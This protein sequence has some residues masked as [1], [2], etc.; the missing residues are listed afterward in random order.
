[1]QTL[2]LISYCGYLFTGLSLS[3]CGTVYPAH[4]MLYAPMGINNFF[5]AQKNETHV[6]AMYR[7]SLP[8]QNTDF[9][10]HADG[11]DF[12][13]G[14]AISDHIGIMAN[15][16]FSNEKDKYNNNEESIKYKR[17]FAELSVGYFTK[18]KN[19][20]K[21][22]FEI[23]GG[24][25]Y[26]SNH[27]KSFY[28]RIYPQGFYNNK[29]IK[30]FLQPAIVLRPTATLQMGLLTKLSFLRYQHIAT[31]Y[32]D[33]FLS[34]PDVR[35]FHTRNSTYSFLEP[36]YV[37]QFPFSKNGWLRGSSTVGGSIRTGGSFAFH[38]S[39]LMSI[40]LLVDAHRIPFK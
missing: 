16:S 36:C 30:F 15:Y 33:D 9:G 39:L 14:Y 34:D 29:S 35:L 40:G 4:H 10:S 19:N 20:R 23:Y 11:A 24:Y 38:R 1:M 18:F 28:N 2:K 13:A 22:I 6:K 27:L 26:G 12:S 31:D 25:G 21:L 17:S 5:M 37:I 32:T 7:K 3:S 8:D